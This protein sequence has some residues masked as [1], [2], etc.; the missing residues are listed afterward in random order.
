MGLPS[1]RRGFDSLHLHILVFDTVLPLGNGTW[2][3]LNHPVPETEY[4]RGVTDAERGIIANIAQRLVH[5]FTKSRMQVRFLLFAQM[6]MLRVWEL[7]QPW[8]LVHYDKAEKANCWES[9]YYLNYEQSKGVYWIIY[10]VEI[11]SIPPIPTNKII[12]K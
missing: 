5:R 8:R 4:K 3:D 2:R 11:G 6:G 9:T 7:G 10:K 1:P 12:N